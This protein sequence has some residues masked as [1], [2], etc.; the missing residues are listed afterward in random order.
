MKCRHR[1][2]ADDVRIAAYLRTSLASVHAAMREA[3]VEGC[4]I[5]DRWFMTTEQAK[6]VVLRVVVMPS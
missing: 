5:G 2:T 3:G 1:H 4:S 6:R